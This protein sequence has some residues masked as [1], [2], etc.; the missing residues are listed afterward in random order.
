[1]MYRVNRQKLDIQPISLIMTLGR[2]FPS[3]TQVMHH[4]KK[5]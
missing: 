1:M 2:N 5:T 4:K 3:N